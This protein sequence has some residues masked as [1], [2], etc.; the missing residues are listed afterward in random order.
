MNIQ[1]N[2]NLSFKA[3]FINT[4]SLKEVV[5]YAEKNNKLLE[6]DGALNKLGNINGKDIL[7]IHGKTPS[8]I[9]SSFRMG[10]RS[11]QNLSMGASSPQ[12]SSYNAILE[13]STMGRKLK[14]LLGGDVKTNLTAEQIIQKYGINA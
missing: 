5:E 10:N 4:K 2:S 8:G 11:V 1:D 6:L 13:L 3:K 9:Y 12:E 7:I 14:K